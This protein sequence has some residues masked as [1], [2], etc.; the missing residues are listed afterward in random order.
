VKN[1]ANVNKEQSSKEAKAPLFLLS[2]AAS[3]RVERRGGWQES[4]G[5]CL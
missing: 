3:T 1:E 4:R 2:P 5:V